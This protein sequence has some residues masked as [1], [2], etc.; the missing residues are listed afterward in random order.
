MTGPNHR[1]KLKCS[2]VRLGYCYYLKVP[3][4]YSNRWNWEVLCCYL[5]TKLRPALCN[6][7]DYSLPGFSVHGILQAKILEWVAI[8]FFKR[9]SW[10]RDW[11]MSPAR[12]MDSYPWAT[13]KAWEVLYQSIIFFF[14]FTLCFFKNVKMK[15]IR[16]SSIKL[17]LPAITGLFLGIL[18]LTSLITYLLTS[19]CFSYEES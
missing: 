14:L 6:A 15:S 1:V 4:D 18:I 13:W 19:S 7:I 17:E 3:P 8:S 16:F 10:P 2:K 12:Q 11:T 5:V 9:S